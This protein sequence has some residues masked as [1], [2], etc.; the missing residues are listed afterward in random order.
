MIHLCTSHLLSTYYD[1]HREQNGKEERRDENE[2]LDKEEAPVPGVTKLK[3]G[4]ISGVVTGTSAYDDRGEQNSLATTRDG[5]WS[6]T[7]KTE[8]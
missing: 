5:V 6:L 7:S 8:K 4:W 1:K 2:H 3:K